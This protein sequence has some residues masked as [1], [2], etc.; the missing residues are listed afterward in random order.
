METTVLRTFDNY[1]SANILLNRLEQSGI[2][3]FLLDEYTVTI[4]PILSNAI[5]GIKLAVQ[6][7]QAEEALELLKQFDEEYLRSVLCPRCGKNN[8]IEVT[9][10][11]PGNIIT[12][13]LTWL[14]SSYAIATE[15]VYQCQDCGYETENLPYDN[16]INN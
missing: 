6:K 13:V 10:Q 9:K 7:E 4:D 5:G 2:H 12:A 16:S 3:C 14:F 8:V 1:F 11:S 15:K